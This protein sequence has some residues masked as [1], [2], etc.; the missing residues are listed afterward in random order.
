MIAKEFHSNITQYNAALA[1]T[2][3]GTDE[4]DLSVNHYGPSN[5]VFRLHGNIRHLS[6]ALEPPPGMSPSYAQLYFYDPTVALHL[7]MDRN[8]NLSESTMHSLQNMLRTFNDYSKIYEHTYQ[9][10][11]RT[12]VPEASIHLRVA[13]GTDHRRYNLPT[14]NEV[15]VIIPNEEIPKDCR[16]IVLR[17]HTPSD[18]PALI[19]ISE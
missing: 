5:W 2:S 10:L 17:K 6:A 18:E 14:A 3:L 7:R 11:N 8:S 19:H 9:L 13:T 12:N 1:F 16:D 4:I 15:A